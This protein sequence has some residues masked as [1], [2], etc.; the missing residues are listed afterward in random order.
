MITKLG[1][2][3]DLLEDITIT[4]RVLSTLKKWTNR[5]LRKFNRVLHL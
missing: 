1:T 3:F 4:Q 2:V 5:A